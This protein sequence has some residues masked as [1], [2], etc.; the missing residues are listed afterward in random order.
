MG[1][2]VKIKPILRKGSLCSSASAL[3]RFTSCVLAA[4]AR[5]EVGQVLA[6]YVPISVESVFPFCFN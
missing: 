2:S 6:R 1:V 4:G 5:S 3:V